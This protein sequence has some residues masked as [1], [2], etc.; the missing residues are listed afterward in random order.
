MEEWYYKRDGF[1]RRNLV[2]RISMA[3]KRSK[4]NL[5]VPNKSDCEN[6][7]ARYR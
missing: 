6:P 5:V 3:R 1:K 4:S 2:A 7:V